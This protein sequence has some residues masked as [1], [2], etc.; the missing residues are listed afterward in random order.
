MKAKSTSKL[1][2]GINVHPCLYAYKGTNPIGRMLK[3][4]KTRASVGVHKMTD[5][6]D[7]GKLIVE[8]F[9][10]VEGQDSV[11]GIYNALYPV[12]ITVLLDAIGMM[13]IIK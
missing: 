12:Y 13:R 5:K 11:V 8:E 3:D 7:E 1:L 9:V 6:V 2:G 4:G 10:S